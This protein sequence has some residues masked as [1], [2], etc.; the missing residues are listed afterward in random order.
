ML[1]K[2]LAA[3]RLKEQSNVE[4]AL[5]SDAAFDVSTGTA[6]LG[7]ALFVFSSVAENLD[8]P[9]LERMIFEQPHNGEW[10]NLGMFT[11]GTDAESVLVAEAKASFVA[12][13]LAER[14]LRF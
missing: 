13:N 9:E 7:G 6:R 14:I 11:V 4:F 10:L 5:F 2:V 1:W 12:W 3:K 8:D